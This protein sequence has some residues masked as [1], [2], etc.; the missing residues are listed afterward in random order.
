VLSNVVI[1]ANQSGP[2][3]SATLTVG[4][5]DA[6]ATLTGYTQTRIATN[7]ARRGRPRTRLRSVLVLRAG[8]VVSAGRVRFSTALNADGRRLLGEHR[9][10]LIKVVVTVKAVDGGSLSEIRSVSLRQRRHT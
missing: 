10:L 2:R 6:V 8:R 9:R 3:V 7:V 1:A 4:G 5:S